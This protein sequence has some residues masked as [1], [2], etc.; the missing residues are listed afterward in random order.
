MTSSNRD[1]SI[2]ERMIWYCDEI[3]ATKEYFGDSKEAL[4]ASTIYMHALSMCVLQIGELATKLTPEFKESHAG[5]PWADMKGMRNKAAHKYGEFSKDFLWD[6]VSS[7][8]DEL[9]EYCKKC[10]QELR[11]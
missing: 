3:D 10:I 8:T 7:D 4:L 6:T 2:L 9:R 5:V 11:A 1:I